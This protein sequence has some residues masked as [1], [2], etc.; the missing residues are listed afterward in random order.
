[1]ESGWQLACHR[2]GQSVEN[3]LLE[4]KRLDNRWMAHNMKSV[5]S[6]LGTV[7]ISSAGM[8]PLTLEVI[9]DFADSKP[10]IR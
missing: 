8:Q 5:V 10:N 3:K 9:S 6:K 7:Q 4:D 2:G 1:M